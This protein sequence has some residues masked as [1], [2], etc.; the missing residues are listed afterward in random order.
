MPTAASI[1]V[2]KADGTTDIVWNLVNASGGDK[3]PAVFRQTSTV[4][5][6]GQRPWLSIA[7][8][9]NTDGTVRRLDYTVKYP[10]VY[11]DTSSSLSQI[12]STMNLTCSVAVPQDVTDT[13]LNEFA[14]QAMNLL[15][16]ALSKASIVAGYA[17]T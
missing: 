16:S 14:A 11:T 8:K 3:T 5:T 2:K 7:S 6:I 15:A 17:P 10:S 9:S 13:D 4:G 12:R 1:T